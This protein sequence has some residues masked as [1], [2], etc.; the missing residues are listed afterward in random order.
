MCSSLPSTFLELNGQDLRREPLEVRKATLASCCVSC[1]HGVR[2]NEH[3][4]DPGDSCS[5]TPASWG[6]RASSRSGWAH[7]IA[8]AV[9]ATGSSSRTRQRLR[10][11]GRQR[12]TGAGGG[13][14]DQRKPKTVQ[15]AAE[16]VHGPV[17]DAAGPVQ[18][19]S[20]LRRG[21]G[22]AGG[23][24]RGPTM[25][26]PPVACSIRLRIRVPWRPCFACA[27]ARMS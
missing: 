15:V 2:L 17:G 26:P 14:G 1:Q 16:L 20:S 5:S 27:G 23:Q 10:S 13:G 4:A 12:R 24:L 6:L 18:L 7:A 3:I 11:G 25:K 9:T 22:N 21:S 8:Q 19:F